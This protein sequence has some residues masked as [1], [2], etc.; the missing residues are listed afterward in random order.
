LPNSTLELP[1]SIGPA[2]R[3]WVTVMCGAVGNHPSI[4]PV[5]ANVNG[6]CVGSLLANE[7]VPALTP[8]TAV[9]NWI[10]KVSLSPD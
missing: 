5:M 8:A 7:T 2:G 10:V 3:A 9:S 4:V 6:F 1:L